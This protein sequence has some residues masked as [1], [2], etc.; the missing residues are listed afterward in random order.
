MRQEDLA[1]TGHAFE[2]RLYA[3]DVPAGFLPATGRLT[4]SCAS[5]TGARADTGVR[6]GR[7]D[8]PVVRPDDRQDHRPRPDARARRCASSTGR[9]RETRGGGHRDQPRLPRRAGAASRVSPRGDVDT[10]LIER[11]LDGADRGA[12]AVRPAA[13][14]AAVLAAAGLWEGAG[15]L[16]GFAL[17]APLQRRIGAAARRDRRSPALIASRRRTGCGSRWTGRSAMAER[18]ADGWWID[19]A[20]APGPV[21]VAGGRIHV[22]DRWRGQLRALSIRWTRRRAGGGGRQSS[23]LSPMPGLV[24]AVFVTAGQTVAQ[25]DRLA[26]LEAM[27]MEHTLTA[28]R[29]GVVAEVLVA[30]GAQ[31]EAGAA[32]VRLEDGGDD[33]AAPRAPGPLVPHPLAAGGARARVRDRARIPSSTS[34]CARPTTWRSRP[35]GRVPALEIDG[36]VLFESGAITE[37]LCETRQARSAACRARRS[38]SDGWSGC[39]SPRRRASIWRR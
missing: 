3:E 4:P 1:I 8:Q 31:V 34:R 23:T 20:K 2:A 36:E 37:Y 26:V 14:A 19:G 16:A 29:D 28:G 27:K 15:P 18:R 21:I 22:F 35:P 6:A 25:G 9:W 39:I 13:T 24:K 12:R 7:R 11:D 30:E 17:W 5:R 33:P 32:L 10:G 38:G